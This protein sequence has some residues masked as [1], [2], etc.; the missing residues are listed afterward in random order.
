MSADP[1]AFVDAFTQAFKPLATARALA[2]WESATTGTPAANER[3][4]AAQEAVMC[5]L[6]DPERY[7]TAKRLHEAGHPDPQVARQLKLIYLQT[8]ANQQDE[9]TIRRLT[10]L[11]AGVRARYY[12]FRGVLDGREVSDNEIEELLRTTTDPDLARR[13]WEASKQVGAQV[14]AD[15][16]E[17]ARVRNAA[18]RAQGFRDHFQR[19]LT[20][21]EI[22]EGYLLDLFDRLEEQTRPLFRDLKARI[23][24]ARAAR[25]GIPVSALRPWHFG[26]RFFQ[27]PPDLGEAGLD[28]LF[29]G[30]DPVPL[31]TRTYDGLGLEVRDILARSDL[32]ERPGKNQHAFSTHIDREG[33]VRTLNNLRPT[34]RWAETLL[35][36][37]GHGVYDKYTDYGLPWLLRGPAH[38]LSTEAIANLMGGLTYDAEWLARVLGVPAAEAGRVPRA[39]RERECADRLVFTRWVLVMT[40]FERQFYADPE[41][42]LDTLWWDLVER[43]QMLTRPEDRHNPD[44]AAKFHIALVPVYYHNYELG[45]LV[46]AQVRARLE[47]VAGGIVDRPAAGQWLV[48]RVFRP[49]KRED[50]MGHVRTATGQALDPKYFVQLA[51]GPGG[52]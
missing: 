41:R 44:W 38:S 47:E 20:L 29:A 40:H 52:R 42:D 15:I 45:H 19:A 16:R 1:T 27:T 30:R 32:Y 23:D 46:A 22:D 5:F 33:D 4:R 21:G 28:P 31:A 39:A 11:E 10:E 3:E 49:G 50:W 2:H 6:A 34:H 12:N 35:H 18:A 51:Q 9:A 25:F 26:D 14:A 43:Y 8:A 24:Q 37:L 17:L 13:A 48:E 36:E 7:A